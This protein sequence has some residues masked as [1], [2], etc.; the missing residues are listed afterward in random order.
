MEN[1]LGDSKYMSAVHKEGQ[2][3]NNDR[4]AHFSQEEVMLA[5]TVQA[6]ALQLPTVRQP[7]K[8]H[9]DERT[10]NCYSHTAA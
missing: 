3:R 2:R 6:L 9:C 4:N 10:S 8:P 7:I 5:P 1:A